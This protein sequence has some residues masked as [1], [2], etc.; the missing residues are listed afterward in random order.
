[1]IQE[2]L[3]KARGVGPINVWESLRDLNADTHDRYFEVHLNSTLEKSLDAR[4]RDHERSG[5][6]HSDSGMR[7]D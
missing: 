7:L 3:W 1:M 2:H 6:F 5:S 4:L